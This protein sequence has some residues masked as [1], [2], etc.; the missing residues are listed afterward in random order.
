MSAGNYAPASKLVKEKDIFVPKMEQVWL[1][2]TQL[3]GWNSVDRRP[4]LSSDRRVLGQM[5]Y[6]RPRAR[7]DN[8]LFPG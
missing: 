6:C 8:L 4:K 2:A 3:R 7:E 1:S 5:L